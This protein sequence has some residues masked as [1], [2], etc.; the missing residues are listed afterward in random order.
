MLP[1]GVE[2]LRNKMD[3]IYNEIIIYLQNRLKNILSIL[4]KDNKIK[5]TEI[6][7]DK[8]LFDILDENDII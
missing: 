6:G 5:F 1:T 2:E 3:I 8:S 4:A 7:I